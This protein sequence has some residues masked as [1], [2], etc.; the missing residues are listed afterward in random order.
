[1]S[2]IARFDARARQWPKPA[3]W[4]YVGIKWYLILGG[5]F[6]LIRLWLDRMGLWPI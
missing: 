1:M 3:Y 2:W 6:L 4:A 5:A